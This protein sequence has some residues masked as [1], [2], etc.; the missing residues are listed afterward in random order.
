MLRGL[1][2]S[3]LFLVVTCSCAAGQTAALNS[4]HHELLSLVPDPLPAGLAKHGALSFYEP[5]NLYQYMDGGADIFVLY[6]MRTL[7]H[8]DLRV[9]DVDVTLDVFD[10]GSADA[11][12]GMYAAERSP[13]YRFTSIGAEGYESPGILNFLQDRYYIKLAGFGDGADAVLTTFARALSGK[14]GSSRALPAL[15]SKLPTDNRKPHS[16]QYMPNDPLGHPFLGPAYV[17]TYAAGDQETKLFVTL[18]Q[19]NDDAQQRLKQLEGHFL[20]TGQCKA[21]HEPGEGAIHCSNS[22]EGSVIAQTRGRY[23][24]LLL[25]PGAGS[26]QLMRST[27][28]ALM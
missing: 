13:D 2:L 16:E 12:F 25:N 20:K 6:G 10:M 14:I 21:A 1:S 24:F 7:L 17:V 28:E 22:F 19:N 5:E 8:M 23:L 3:F 15:L 4:D 11:A 18:A 26:E 9:K 27:A